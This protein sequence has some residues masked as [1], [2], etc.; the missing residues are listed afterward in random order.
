M[1]LGAAALGLRGVPAQKAGAGQLAI[2]P[3]VAFH[4]DGAWRVVP[5]QGLRDALT[6]SHTRAAVPLL[7]VIF[8]Q[9]AGTEAQ[10]GAL[11]VLTER[12]PTHCQHELTL[13]H[14]CQ[15]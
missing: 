13:V 4:A 7:S 6:S 2:L 14:V 1:A 10:E 8:L 3:R 9:V 15:A 12:R 11:H 5:W